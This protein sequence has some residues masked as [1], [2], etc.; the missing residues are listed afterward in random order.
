MKE[1]RISD[2]DLQRDLS[3]ALTA[4]LKKAGFHTG[5]ASDELCTVMFPIRLD[6]AGRVTIGRDE[7]GF[8]TF[9][10]E[11]ELDVS[12]R[13]AFVEQTHAAAIANRE[14]RPCR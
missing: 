3:N 11:L 12:E 7:S 10:Q 5:A 9:T 1:V 13:T 8:W 2:A 14:A 4:R 6:L